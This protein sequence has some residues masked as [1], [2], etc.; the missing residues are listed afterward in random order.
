M[1]EKDF[2]PRVDRMAKLLRS[3]LEELVKKHP[4][5]YA[6]VRGAGLLLGL[7]CVPTNTQVMDA[8]RQEG[9]LTVS[10]G[11]NVLRLL[12]PLIVDEAQHLAPDVLEQIRVISNLETSQAKLLQIVLVGQL[13]LLDVLATAAM[14]PLDQRISSLA[15]LRPI[16]LDEV[17]AYVSHRLE[18]AQGTTR[19]SFSD[20]A[21]ERLHAYSQGVPR[22]INLICDRALTRAAAR[23]TDRV[24]SELVDDAARELRLTAT[25]EAAALPAPPATHARRGGLVAIGVAVIISLAL[26]L[27]PVDRL[28]SAPI[29]ALPA[30]PARTGTAAST[31]SVGQ[32]RRSSCTCTALTASRSLSDIVAA[33]SP[34][35]P[36]K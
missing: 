17:S 29:P 35:P 19:V 28:V 27:T 20:S 18:V 8:L 22:V 30:A 16:S 15:T 36:A 24:T 11:E 4:K 3:K 1:L 14:R 34:M 9:L 5:A 7:L 6:E 32:S 21:I 33:A 13:N 26:W 2:L 31:A 10:A 12:P 25:A 23:E